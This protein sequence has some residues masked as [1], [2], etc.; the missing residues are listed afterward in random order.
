MKKYLL[1]DND[2]VLVETERWYYEASIRALSELGV[3]LDFQEYM[4][5]M[6]EGN[7]VWGKALQ[8]GITTKQIDAARDRRNRY[9]QEYLR[10]KNLVIEGV[11]PTLKRLSKSF[12]MAIVT[13]SRR[14][15]FEIIHQQSAICELMKF[16]L[17]EGEYPRAKPYPDP[18]LKALSLFK[19]AKEEALIIEDSERGLRSAVSAQIECVIVHNEFTKTQDFSKA[20]HRVQRLEEI[21]ALL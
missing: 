15:D 16:I 3:R 10:S 5:A 12:E 7:G 11:L 14:V 18:Y 8:M 2:G 1:F 9:Y 20:T 4:Q 19:G 6:T 13:T 17:C 21:E